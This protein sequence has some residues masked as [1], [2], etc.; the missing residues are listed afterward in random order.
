V[1]CSGER[2]TSNLIRCEPCLFDKPRGEG[3]IC[4]WQLNTRML[5][6]S[7]LQLRKGSGEWCAILLDSSHRLTMKM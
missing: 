3:V 1:P 4:R 7:F 6:S 5:L 2:E